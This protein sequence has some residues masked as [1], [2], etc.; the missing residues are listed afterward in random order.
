MR[1]KIPGID[2][3]FG[4]PALHFVKKPGNPGRRSD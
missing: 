3:V 4:Y 1:D 2:K